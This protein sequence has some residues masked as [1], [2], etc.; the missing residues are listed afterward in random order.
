MSFQNVY[1]Q[2]M[3]KMAIVGDKKVERPRGDVHRQGAP[4]LPCRILSTGRCGPSQSLAHGEHI[5]AASSRRRVAA[6]AVDRPVHPKSRCQTHA[7]DTLR[8]EPSHDQQILSAL[9]FAPEER[10]QHAAPL[11]GFAAV[12]LLS[13]TVNAAIPLPTGQCAIATLARLLRELP[14]A[15]RRLGGLRKQMADKAS[16]SI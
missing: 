2:N 3:E 6:D 4:P 16:R 10:E 15:H 7:L 13:A 8:K 1:D 14:H 11:R 12:T 5:T 9:S